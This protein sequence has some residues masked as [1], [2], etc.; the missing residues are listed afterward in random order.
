MGE[1]QLLPTGRFT[2]ILLASDG[3]EYTRNAQAVAIALA[4]QFDGQVIASQMVVTNPEYEALAQEAVTRQEEEVL[5]SLKT[6]QEAAAA[7]G[8]PCNP[9]VMHGVYPHEEI[10]AT[11]K[12]QQADLVVMGRRGRRGLAR[13]MVG[14]ATARV[15]AQ[16]PCKVLVVPRTGAMWQRGILLATDGSRY[17]DRAGVVATILAKK[18]ALPLT[19]ISVVDDPDNTKKRASATE[20]VE[21]VVEHARAEG[22]T[23]NGEVVTGGNPA[24]AIAESV[25]KTAADLVVGGSHGRTGLEKVFLGSVM[26]RVIGVVPCA[27]LAIKGG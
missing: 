3:S 9:Y 18:A 15:V 25:Q 20:A 24:E 5:V 1:G 27:V 16:S 13:F 7:Q 21:R 26:E 23:V 6:I 22:V 19:V 11:A 14:D 8:V 17:S 10:I 4:K 2:R 12:S